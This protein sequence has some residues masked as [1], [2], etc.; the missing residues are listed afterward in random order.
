MAVGQHVHLRQFDRRA[1]RDGALDI[2][3]VGHTANQHRVT[4]HS[5][6]LARGEHH[7]IGVGEV[8]AESLL[9]QVLVDERGDVL[10]VTDAGQAS[11][12][13][14]AATSAS[15]GRS[16]TTAAATSMAAMAMPDTQATFHCA[17][18]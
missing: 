6:I 11:G 13:V 5:A 1:Q 3:V 16:A 18:C 7:A 2:V 9:G 14:R 15:S 17:R 8:V 12:N 10:G 4:D